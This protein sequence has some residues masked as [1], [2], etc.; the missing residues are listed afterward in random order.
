MAFPASRLPPWPLLAH[1]PC[2]PLSL[3]LSRS[4]SSAHPR[5][6]YLALHR[7]GLFL[8]NVPVA[9]SAVNNSFT[10]HGIVCAELGPMLGTGA[11]TVETLPTP[12]GSP[13]SSEGSPGQLGSAECCGGGKRSGCGTRPGTLSPPQGRKEVRGSLA[14]QLSPR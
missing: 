8:R 1:I 10:K 14:G 12:S 9:L 3:P 13:G 4:P 6:V 7:V 11:E 5:S 2:S